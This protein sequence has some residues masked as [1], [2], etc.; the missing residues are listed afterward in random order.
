MIE[1]LPKLLLGQVSRRCFAA[2]F[3][4]F[5]YTVSLT[6]R[7]NSRCL[8]CRIYEKKS[9]QL[10]VQEYGR[11]FRSWGRAPYWVTFSGGEPFLREDLPRIVA[12]LYRYSRP[13]IV[14]IPTNGLLHERIPAFVEH[15]TATCPETKFIVNLSLDE[16]GERHD[17]IRG[18]KGNY[19]RAMLCYQALRRLRSPNLT[20]GIHTVISRFNVR[21]FPRVYAELMKLRPDSYVTEIAEERVELGTM[22]KQITP[23]PEQYREA[24]DFLLGQIK[25]RSFK[26][27]ARLTQAL[28]LE[29]YQMVK[30]VLLEKKRL[31]P[32]YAGLF[33]VQIAPN[34]D[35][36]PCCIKARV[37]GNLRDFDFDFKKLWRSPQ[38][39]GLQ[40]EI[41]Q[42]DCWCPLANAAYTNMLGCFPAM[43]RVGWRLLNWPGA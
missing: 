9:G 11:I 34:G 42:G 12:L 29:Y 20:L 39:G 32:C 40:R 28:R 30:R 18:V 25:S 13:R 23:C 35:V 22:G 2:C 5:N 38:S 27:I 33:S 14:N 37:M 6:Y 19:A 1:L 36:W 4:P 26:G 43:L 41:E 15:F 8:T 7:C 31:L 24:I 17:R 3:L 16:I 21:E 10:T